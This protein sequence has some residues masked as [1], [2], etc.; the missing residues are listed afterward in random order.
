MEDISTK[1]YAD[2]DNVSIVVTATSKNIFSNPKLY[3]DTEFGLPVVIPKINYST[4][5][6][7]INANF[8]FEKKLLSKNK[9]N[10]SVI[11][12]DNN[13]A[14]KLDTY[15]NI[16]ET[17]NEIIKNK[18]IIY[19]FLIALFGGLILNIMPCVLPV[20]SIKL[21]SV[22]QNSNTSS[23]I[24]KSFI[25]TSTGIIASFILLAL[26]LI[27]LRLIGINIGWGMQFQQ[28]LFLM[29]IALIL[30]LFALNLFGIFEFKTPTI[31]NSGILM[32]LN[33]NNYSKDFFNGF[34]ATI[35]A[36]PCS[37]PF[38]GHC[39][40][41]GI[42]TIFFFH[43][44]NILFYGFRNG[45][46]IS[47]NLTVSKYDYNFTKTWSM[48]EGHKIF[49]WIIIINNSYLDWFYPSESFQ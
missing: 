35:L 21:L 24:R 31:I 32:K 18:S 33:N 47:I 15:V 23:S 25:I 36:T 29:T 38:C 40:Y 17:N 44:W 4:N 49:S 42:Y 2:K 7:N 10:I 22:L 30:F 41:R 19:F 26:F 43:D 13:K 28:P 9:F 20:L 16:E 6:K 48:D 8:V 11:L 1:A 39:Y 14:F 46:T 27:C 34:F 3:L 12:N 5:Y 37:A 45:S